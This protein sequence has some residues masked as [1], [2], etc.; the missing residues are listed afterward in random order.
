MYEKMEVFLDNFFSSVGQFAQILA[1][2]LRTFRI[3][4]RYLIVFRGFQ[5]MKKTPGGHRQSDAWVL[6][7][8]CRCRRTFLFFLF[9]SFLCR[10]CAV[11]RQESLRSLTAF[12]HIASRFR[13][14]WAAA[15]TCLG[16]SS[17]NPFFASRRR[18]QAKQGCQV[19]S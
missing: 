6:R 17:P 4:R 13:N 12:A 8:F 2:F 10:F 3:F 19:S 16:I 7:P 14:D 5:C 11:T 18:Q 15:Q 1:H 9:F